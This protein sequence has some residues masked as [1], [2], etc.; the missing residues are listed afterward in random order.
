M[1]EGEYNFVGF[2]FAKKDAASTNL[3]A[4]R[5]IKIESE[6]EMIFR[7]KEEKKKIFI[8]FSLR[9]SLSH[10]KVVTS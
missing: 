3:I 10:S 6:D 5:V 4:D 1:C 7:S 2:F 8:Y 9:H